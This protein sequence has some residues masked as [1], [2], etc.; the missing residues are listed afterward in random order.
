MDERARE[1]AARLQGATTAG[2]RVT[3]GRRRAN[4]VNP[5][6][7]CSIYRGTTRSACCGSFCHTTRYNGSIPIISREDRARF[8]INRLSHDLNSEFRSSAAHKSSGH[9]DDIQD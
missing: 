2:V 1:V 5:D 6:L 3:G 7:S 9:P 8:I 4:G